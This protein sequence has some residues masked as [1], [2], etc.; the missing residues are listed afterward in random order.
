[1]E[2]FNRQNIFFY[3]LLFF[4]GCT[5]F[6][7]PA[8]VVIQTPQTVTIEKKVIGSGTLLIDISKGEHL[9]MTYINADEIKKTFEIKGIAQKKVEQAIQQ[10]I[11]WTG[12]KEKL[13][14]AI[15]GDKTSNYKNFKT[16]TEALRKKE[17]YKYK[18]ITT[19]E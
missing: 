5:A 14:A 16:I 4:G 8:P 3:I 18:L 9:A 17:I 6:I 10:A 19:P 7:P 13:K 15:K 2:L 1:M 12:N 11:V